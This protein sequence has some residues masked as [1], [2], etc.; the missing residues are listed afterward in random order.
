[1][2]LRENTLLYTPLHT[3]AHA[4]TPIYMYM[5]FDVLVL[6]T[7]INDNCGPN[8]C[9]FS[10]FLHIVL[11]G[12]N[13]KLQECSIYM[14]LQVGKLHE[15][16]YKLNFYIDVLIYVIILHMSD[17]HL[18]EQKFSVLIGAYYENQSFITTFSFYRFRVLI[19]A[20]CLIHMLCFDEMIYNFQLLISLAL[21]D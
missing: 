13:F 6:Q 16:I 5:Q 7:Q 12:L 2:V 21:I 17:N 3:H 10:K 15:S 9:I 1:M 19:R 14:C 11:K 20:Q 18:L 8:S 4:H